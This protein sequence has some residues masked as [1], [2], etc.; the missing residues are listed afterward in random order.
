MYTTNTLYRGVLVQLVTDPLRC[1]LS[2]MCR[3]TTDTVNHAVLAVGYG[4]EEV[5]GVPYWIVK[6]SWGPNWGIDG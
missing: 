1:A 5:G 6:N 4:V 3:N 2:S